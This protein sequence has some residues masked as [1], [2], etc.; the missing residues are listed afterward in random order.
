VPKTK[1]APGEITVPPINKFPEKLYR[2]VKSSAAQKGIPMKEF[3]IQSLRYALE[4]D[5]VVKGKPV[6][7]LEN[8]SRQRTVRRSSA[9]NAKQAAK[10]NRK[11]KGQES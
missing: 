7:N 3:L 1:N 10:E 6:V 5:D 8:E 9:P 4:N 2:S 11:N